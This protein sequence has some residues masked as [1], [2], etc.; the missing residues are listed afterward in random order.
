MPHVNRSGSAS[1]RGT[2]T[3]PLSNTSN[4]TMAGADFLMYRNVDIK[5]EIMASPPDFV[6]RL[7]LSL[8]CGK[9]GFIGMGLDFW[10]EI[11]DLSA[12]EYRVEPSISCLAVTLKGVKMRWHRK[13]KGD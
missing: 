6:K 1:D 7:S 3:Q 8:R 9:V 13:F 10:V 5:Q 2:A 11:S 12:T 4:K